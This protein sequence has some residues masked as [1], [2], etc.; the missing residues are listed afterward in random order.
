MRVVHN[1][2]PRNVTLTLGEVPIPKETVSNNP[3]PTTTREKPSAPEQPRIGVAVTELTPDIAKELKMPTT[4]KGIVIGEV[5]EGS[6]A[7]EAGLEIG[8]V[9]AEVD[10][11]PVKTVTDFRNTIANHTSSDPILLLITREGHSRFVAVQRR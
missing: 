3:P 5:E 9:I 11:K 4:T 2:E 7:S 8:D 10:R 6:S 1:G